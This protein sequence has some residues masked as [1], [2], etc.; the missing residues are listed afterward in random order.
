MDRKLTKVLTLFILFYLVGCGEDANDLIT[1]TCFSSDS[2]LTQSQFPQIQELSWLIV[3]IEDVFSPS[4]ITKSLLKIDSIYVC[5]LGEDEWW[6]EIV[7]SPPKDLITISLEPKIVSTI[8][9]RVDLIFSGEGEYDNHLLFRNTHRVTL[10][11]KIASWNLFSSDSTLIDEQGNTV[12]IKLEQE[13]SIA[14]AD[15]SF[16]TECGYQLGMYKIV[17]DIL[18]EDDNIYD[19][20]NDVFINV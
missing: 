2:S 15:S 7:Y 19:F 1:D 9:I 20:Y 17:F 18:P 6:W 12:D 11:D 8:L 13:L 5:C 10:N 3:T 16:F 4:R 14:I